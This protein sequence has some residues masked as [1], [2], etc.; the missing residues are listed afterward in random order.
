MIDNQGFRPKSTVSAKERE[1]FENYRSELLALPP[2][3]CMEN[4]AKI[5]AFWAK[6]LPG[7]VS[8]FEFLGLKFN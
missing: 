7:S 8:H 4:A 2:A 5:R 3:N 1:E 6:W